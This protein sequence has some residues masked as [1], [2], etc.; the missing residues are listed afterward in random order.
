M[1]FFLIQNLKGQ[2]K[3]TTLFWPLFDAMTEEQK[4]RCHSL[5]LVCGGVALSSG[6]DYIFLTWLNLFLFSPKGTKLT[7]V[8]SSLWINL[9]LSLVRNILP[10]EIPV[11]RSL[12][13]NQFFIYISFL[14]TALNSYFMNQAVITH[15]V[16]GPQRGP[17]SGFMRSALDHIVFQTETIHGLWLVGSTAMSLLLESI[18]TFMWF[19]CL[20]LQTDPSSHLK[21]KK[22]ETQSATSDVSV[23]RDLLLHIRGVEPWSDG[24]DKRPETTWKDLN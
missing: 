19:S 15:W 13:W 8:F 24:R 7:L 10:M 16:R 12:C 5:L 2:Q 17:L 6:A 14:I 23:S 22:E 21:K 3:T 18:L 9:S 11:P 20:R 4:R 1:N